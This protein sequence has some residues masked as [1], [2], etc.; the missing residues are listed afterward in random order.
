MATESTINRVNLVSAILSVVALVLIFIGSIPIIFPLSLFLG[1][2]GGFGGL[3]VGYLF[4][5][6]LI[7]LQ[8][9]IILG[10]VMNMIKKEP[11][12]NPK[13]GGDVNLK[14]S[15]L[16]LAIVNLLFTLLCIYFTGI[17]LIFPIESTWLTISPIITIVAGVIYQN[18]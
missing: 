9:I 18:Y 5:I 17:F 10:I 16:I 13:T 15:I 8:A 12:V 4:P 7:L 14:K 11:M 2:L 1:V 6:L 3:I